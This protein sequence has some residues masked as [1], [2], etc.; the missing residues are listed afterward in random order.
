MDLTVDQWEVLQAIVP[1]LLRRPD[2]RGRPRREAR[3]VLNGF[4]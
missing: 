3:G 4:L 2:G 1:V